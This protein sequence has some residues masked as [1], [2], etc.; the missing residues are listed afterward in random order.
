[1]NARNLVEFLVR[2]ET[3]KLFRS[4]TGFYFNKQVNLFTLVFF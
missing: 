2:V 4:K 1:M 3:K